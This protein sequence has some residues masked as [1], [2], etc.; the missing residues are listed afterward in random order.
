MISDVPSMPP[1]KY[2]NWTTLSAVILGSWLLVYKM[3]SFLG[4]AYTSDLF[5]F[6][7]LA[8]TWLH[9]DFLYDNCYGNHLSIHTYL[10]VPAL[11]VFVL[12]LGP[13]GLLVALSLSFALGF[14][15][16][17]KILT[18]CDVPE[19][20]ALAWAALVSC[21]P[22]SLHVYQDAIYGFH[23]EL[24]MPALGLWL[25][26]FILRR[27]WK[28]TLAITITLCGL[29][30]ESPLLV[31]AIA[32]TLMAE[33]FVR[34]LIS[35]RPTRENMLKALNK[36]SLA[37]LIIAIVAL[38]TFLYILHAYKPIG[39]SPGSFSRMRPI[40]GTT[41]T[42]GFSFIGYL[43]FNAENWI[44][45][46][47]VISWLGIM[48]VGSLGMVFLRPHILLFGL[49]TTFVTWLMQDDI[50][51]APRLAPTLAVAQFAACL[52]FVSFRRYINLIRLPS[53]RTGI[54]IAATLIAATLS[55]RSQ[56]LM[57][58]DSGQIYK[59]SPVLALSSA[60]RAQAQSVFS[61]YEARRINGEP[62]IASPYLFRYVHYADLYWAD[63]LNGRPEPHW[64]L[65]DF[66]TPPPQAAYSNYVLIKQSG[67]FALFKRP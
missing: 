20:L 39:Y 50:L 15:A 43:Y 56:F 48:S 22:L 28:G 6:A 26:Y 9:G 67:R 40:D 31:L 37:A 38:P 18:H 17:K 11:A 16:M 34:G 36:P 55:I 21:M 63:R 42:D 19:K 65:L 47:Q 27:S 66:G 4:L 35:K 62:A 64:V 59:Q 53:L 29:K 58:P 3:Q 46:T 1:R 5:Q 49:V 8:T 10:A 54:G 14:V 33:D 41:V 45:S 7:Q 60:E 13:A 51:W 23:V 25:A 2:L 61:E 57:S 52:G 24:L 32:G 12:P 44:R 30:E